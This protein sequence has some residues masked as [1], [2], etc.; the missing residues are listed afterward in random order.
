MD[1]GLQ[2][3]RGSL[4][5]CEQASLPH[6][7]LTSVAAFDVLLHLDLRN[8]STDSHVNSSLRQSKTEPLR[9]GVKVFVRRREKELCPDGVCSAVLHDVQTISFAIRLAGTG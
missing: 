6:T 4:V 2:S 3:A 8:V 1:C 5:L 9:Q 7:Y